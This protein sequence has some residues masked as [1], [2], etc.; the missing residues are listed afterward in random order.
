M[1]RTVCQWLLV[2]SADLIWYCHNTLDRHNLKWWIEITFCLSKNKL[3]VISPNGADVAVAVL[4]QTQQSCLRRAPMQI[5]ALVDL[6][7]P[8]RAVDWG[9]TAQKCTLGFLPSLVDFNGNSPTTP[10]LSIVTNSYRD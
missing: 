6:A 8:D 5:L 2:I 3:A 9:A 4:G 10:A 7:A 1:A